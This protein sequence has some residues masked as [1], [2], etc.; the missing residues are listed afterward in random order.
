MWAEI[1]KMEES[2]TIEKFN[3]NKSWFFE[4][5]KKTDKPLLDQKSKSKD[6]NNKSG[7]KE[8]PSL[9]TVENSKS[10]QL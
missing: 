2:K 8:R 7:M 3:E 5:I 9:T 1:N 6:S 10:K 4:E